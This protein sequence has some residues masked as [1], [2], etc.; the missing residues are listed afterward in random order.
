MFSLL[1][2]SIMQ[3][4]QINLGL[5]AVLV[6]LIV[7]GYLLKRRKRFVVHGSAMLLAVILNAVSFLLVM[8]PSFLGFVESVPILPFRAFS[9]VLF[10]HAS[11]GGIAEVLGIYLVASWHLQS[12]TQACIRRKRFMD[13]VFVLWLM[14]FYLGFLLYTLLYPI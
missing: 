5:Q 1:D 6:V 10:T 8:G 3:I 13:V 9:I 11:L 14:V 12:S 2:L 4:A 7:T